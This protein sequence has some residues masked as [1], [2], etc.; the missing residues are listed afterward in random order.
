M[1][2]EIVEAHG[3]GL[4]GGGGGGGGGDVVSFATRSASGERLGVCEREED[5]C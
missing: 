3:K 5:A 1:T 2:Q 4:I